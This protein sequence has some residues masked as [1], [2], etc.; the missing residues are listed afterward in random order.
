MG[1]GIPTRYR[2]LKILTNVSAYHCMDCHK[3]QS[4]VCEE[5]WNPEEHVGH[6]VNL[7]AVHGM[8]D[9]GA[10]VVRNPCHRHP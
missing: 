10:K 7:C 1:A 5:C 3:E 9:C 4:I 8:C 2:Q 6:R